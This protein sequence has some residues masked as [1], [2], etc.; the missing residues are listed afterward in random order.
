MQS[1]Q[2]DVLNVQQIQG[3][4]DIRFTVHSNMGGTIPKEM[5]DSGCSRWRTWEPLPNELI[6]GQ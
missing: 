5:A 2:W 3:H 6:H 1:F 4:K